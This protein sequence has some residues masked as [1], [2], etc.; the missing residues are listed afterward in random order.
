MPNWSDEGFVISAR[1]HG[2]TNAIIG[3]FTA[4]HGRHMGLVH[5]GAS[6]TKKPIIELG[7]FVSAN[8]QARLD[9]QLGTYQLEIQRAYS[10]AFLDDP[11]KLSAL[12]AVCALLEHALPEREPQDA[13]YA[14]TAG[15][16]EVLYLASEVEQWLPIYLKWELGMLDALGFGLD[17]TRCAV[18]GETTNLAYVSPR[19]GHAVQIDHAGPYKDRL[20]PLPSL[21]GGTATLDDEFAKGLALTGHFL[22]KHIFSLIHKELPAARIRLESLIAS[23]YR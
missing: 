11:I 10:G 12:G 7:N 17:L 23:R 18:S 15:L 19:T 4:A 21:L 20:L 1:L 2:E 13:I 5:G 9:D 22:Q 8:W 16:F 6:R 14:A 3:V